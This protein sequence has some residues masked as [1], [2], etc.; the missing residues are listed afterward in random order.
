MKLFNPKNNSKILAQRNLQKYLLMNTQEAN[1]VIAEL[2]PEQLTLLSQQ[3]PIFH[4]HI[5]K[6][7]NEIKRF[8]LAIY[9]ELPENLLDANFIDRTLNLDLF[10]IAEFYLFYS[11][12]LKDLLM[13]QVKTLM[14]ALI[15]LKENFNYKSEYA[16]NILSN[17]PEVLKYTTEFVEACKIEVTNLLLNIH[18]LTPDRL[19]VSYFKSLGHQFPSI[20]ATMQ[21]LLVPPR[22]IFEMQKAYTAIETNDL[23]LSENEIEKV[24][25]AL[26]YKQI[27]L[28]NK[29]V[30]AIKNF[31]VYLVNK[32]ELSE[33]FIRHKLQEAVKNV[34]FNSNDVTYQQ[35]ENAKKSDAELVDMLIS[36]NY[37]DTLLQAPF[38]YQSLRP[39]LICQEVYLHYRAVTHPVYTHDYVQNI[40]AYCIKEPPYMLPLAWTGGIL[41]LVIGGIC[42]LN[43]I[44]KALR[45]FAKYSCGYPCNNTLRLLRDLPFSQKFLC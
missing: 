1:A 45:S 3:L 27:K 38:Y 26:K 16:F 15:S 28:V 33:N 40:P 20:N 5:L 34:L 22:Y 36:K 42:W 32:D 39:T 11:N 6:V 41:V 21:A 43:S 25:L 30:K 18:Y 7:I 13:T 23:F 37:I 9:K 29:A 44:K 35:D 10:P 12:K 8:D 17:E 19:E 31:N 4:R 24:L 14:T 2:N